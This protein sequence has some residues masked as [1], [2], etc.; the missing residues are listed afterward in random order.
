MKAIIDRLRVLGCKKI[1]ISIVYKWNIAS[2]K[3]HKSLGFV[4]AK[5]TENEYFMR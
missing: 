2:Q 5:E 4:C 1:Y 3:L